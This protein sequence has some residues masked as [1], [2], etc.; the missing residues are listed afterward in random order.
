MARTPFFP[1]SVASDFRV[2]LVFWEACWP[3]GWDPKCPREPLYWSYSE[4]CLRVTVGCKLQVMWKCQEW[5]SVSPGLWFPAT[6]RSHAHWPE[7]W[8]VRGWLSMRGR[9]NQ[10]PCIINMPPLSSCTK[11]CL[12]SFLLCPHNRWT[13]THQPC[14]QRVYIVQIKCMLT[15]YSY[16]NLWPTFTFV[17]TCM[18][19]PVYAWIHLFS[20]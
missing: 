9:E 10:P 3:P 4:T 5:S 16:H 11:R 20:A 12:L 8:C 7:V 18:D 1:E 19:V 6:R 14:S 2:I 13:E 17:Y 15:E